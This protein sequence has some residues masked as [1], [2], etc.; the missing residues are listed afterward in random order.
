M[1]YKDGIE[2]A[3]TTKYVD[4]E[5]GA[6][7]LCGGSLCLMSDYGNNNHGHHLTAYIVGS[8]ECFW[9]GTSNVQA[10]SELPVV[11]V[12]E[13]LTLVAEDIAAYRP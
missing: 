8:G 5:A 10:R 7:F 9:G 1:R 2:L 4:L 11:V 3:A 13:H 6:L 12:T